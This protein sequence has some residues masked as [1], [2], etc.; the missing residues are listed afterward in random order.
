MNCP[1][2]GFPHRAARSACLEMTN[3]TITAMSSEREDKRRMKQSVLPFSAL[4]VTLAVGILV[5]SNAACAQDELPDH[6]QRKL[7]TCTTKNG[8]P[9][10]EWLHKL[11]GQY[12]PKSTGFYNPT[13]DSRKLSWHDTFWSKSA[14][15]MWATAGISAAAVIGD[16]RDT[17]IAESH[18]CLEHGEFG[19]FHTTLGRM[20]SVD[21]PTWFGVN[22][23]SFTLRK[24]GIPIAPYAGPLT[25][26]A[27][28]SLGMAHAYQRG[29]M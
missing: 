1:R 9:C 4:A 26:A 17:L 23:F 16:E 19:P 27:K 21:W 25:L 15:P 3:A 29:C 13:L 8:T 22:A 10:P 5:L 20:G 24:L 7:S 28:H 6:P 12:P 14:I 18:G 11:I 2:S